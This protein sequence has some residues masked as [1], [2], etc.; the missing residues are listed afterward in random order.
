MPFAS[1]CFISAV[2]TLL[3]FIAAVSHFRII[4]SVKAADLEIEMPADITMLRRTFYI[5]G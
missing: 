3:L 1:Y 5:G 4:E 2:T